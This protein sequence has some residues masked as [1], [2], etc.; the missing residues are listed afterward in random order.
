MSDEYWV[1]ATMGEQTRRIERLEAE[2]ALLREERAGL[3]EAAQADGALGLVAANID[4]RHRLAATRRR[5]T[6][7]EQTVARLGG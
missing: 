7:L 2:V 3:V 1:K 5:V 4:L 6:E